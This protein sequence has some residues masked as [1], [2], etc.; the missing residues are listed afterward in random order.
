MK[1]INGIITPTVSPIRQNQ[2][3]EYAIEKLMDFLHEIGVSGIFPMGSN[4]ASPFIS[5]KNHKK[6]LD[7]FSKFRRSNEYFIPGVGKNNLEDTIEL[8]KYSEDLESDAIVIVTPYYLKV[9][10]AS[11]FNFIEGVASKINTPIILYNI[12]QFTGNVVLP[13]T[14][15]K[16]SENFSHI[17]GIKDSSGDLSLFQDYLLKLPKDMNIFQGQDEL[18]LA[19]LILGASGGVCGSS[20]FT[21]LSVKVFSS[22]RNGEIGEAIV[23][24]KKL[25][26]L[27]L[28]LNRHQF[29][30]IYSYLFHKMILNE[31]N[32]GT[33]SMLE[34]LS[35]K[36]IKEINNNMK[37]MV[38]V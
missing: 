7:A 12:P 36:E 22:F 38:L 21:N 30:Q 37:E 32:T 17:I 19:S 1:K 15:I 27:K 25:S 8:A 6:I 31:E 20:N 14:V 5:L 16:L 33:T 2:V 3:N 26:E 10:Q 34:P 9:D 18:L 13:E 4:G 35:G 24:Q 11:I 29:P 23:H 28:Y